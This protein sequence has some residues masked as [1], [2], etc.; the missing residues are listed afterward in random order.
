MRT[1]EGYIPHHDITELN[2]LRLTIPQ[3]TT[4]DCCAGSVGRS[5]C[6]RQMP[7]LTPGWCDPMELQDRIDQLKGFPASFR[8]ASSCGWI[9]PLTE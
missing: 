7:W 9:E 3:R 4:V 8:R 2:G 1:V 5:R 6:R